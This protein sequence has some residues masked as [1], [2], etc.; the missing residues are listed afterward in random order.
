[1]GLVSNGKAV[2]WDAKDRAKDA[3]GLM[4]DAAQLASALY[5]GATVNEVM[6]KVKQ[7]ALELVTIK[8]EVEET[9]KNYGK[10]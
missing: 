8:K 6:P 10:T 9:I 5:P 7:I 4:H 1:M 3:G 2:D